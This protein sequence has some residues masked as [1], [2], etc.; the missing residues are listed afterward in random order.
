MEKEIIVYKKFNLPIKINNIKMEEK[1]NYLKMHSHMAIEIVQVLSGTI[2]CYVN[3]DIIELTSKQIIFINSNTGHK[4]CSKKAEISYLQIDISLLEE[5]LNNNEFSSLNA[6]ILHTKSE[7]YLIFKD[8]SELT[9]LLNKMNIKYFDYSKASYWYLKAYIYEL[10]AFMYSQSLVFHFVISKE[11]IKKIEPVVEYV[12][13][14][15]KSPIT[16]D[17]ISNLT[18]YN[19][20]TICHIFKEVSG[21]TIFDYINFLR[22]HFAIERLKETGNSIL[23]IAVECGFSSVTYF[24]RVFKNYLGCSPSIYRKQLSQNIIY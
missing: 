20:Y 10:V 6:F 5:N 9:E 17:D 3:D 18:K 14:N 7:P 24:N 15:F 8:N 13:S 11:Q 1:N 19:K 21:S 22:I 16:L 2:S 4:L 12:N 23:E